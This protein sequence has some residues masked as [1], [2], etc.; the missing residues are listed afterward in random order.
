[1]GKG[2]VLFSWTTLDL[3][4]GKG[5]KFP[6]GKREDVF[7]VDI[8]LLKTMVYNLTQ[9][10]KFSSLSVYV[11]WDFIQHNNCPLWVWLGCGNLVEEKSGS[12]SWIDTTKIVEAIVLL[13]LVRELSCVLW[14]DLS[15]LLVHDCDKSY[16]AMVW[17][18][19]QMWNSY[20]CNFT[21]SWNMSNSCWMGHSQTLNKIDSRS[22]TNL[23]FPWRGSEILA[24]YE[25][26]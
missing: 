11:V 16:V 20:Q 26:N 19:Y 8:L 25:I 15:L 17:I 14:K 13:L 7:F 1:M 24:F 22:K 23:D 6:L 2:A 21:H 3:G 12:Y 9:G 10:V 5:M 18:D 4:L